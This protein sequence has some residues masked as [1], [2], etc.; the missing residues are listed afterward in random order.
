[1]LASRA[2]DDAIERVGAS[3]VG[4]V[5]EQHDGAGRDPS[6]PE[7]EKRAIERVVD[8]RSVGELQGLPERLYETPRVGGQRCENVDAAVERDETE[9]LALSPVPHECARRLERPD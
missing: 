3:D 9:L 2:P 8:P 4:P 5:R 1:M 7:Q 6:P